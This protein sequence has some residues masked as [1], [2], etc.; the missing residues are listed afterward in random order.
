MFLEYVIFI[1]F[2]MVNKS[3]QAKAENIYTTD[4]NTIKM[5]LRNVWPQY[6]CSVFLYVVYTHKIQL[7]KKTEKREGKAGKGSRNKEVIER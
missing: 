5:L 7:E 1:M 6:L 2:R 3:T 4:E